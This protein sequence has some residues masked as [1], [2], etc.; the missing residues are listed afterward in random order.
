MEVQ[1]LSVPLPPTQIVT[2]ASRV[3]LIGSLRQR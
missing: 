1:L 3:R 2:S